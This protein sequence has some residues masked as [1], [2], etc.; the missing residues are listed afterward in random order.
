MYSWCAYMCDEI[1]HSASVTFLENLLTFILN[2]QTVYKTRN[3]LVTL[4]HLK[5]WTDV[6]FC[7]CV[8]FFSDISRSLSPWSFISI[9]Y[10][11]PV[12]RMITLPAPTPKW[13]SNLT[14]SNLLFLFQIPVLVT[15]IS[16]TNHP[17]K[18]GLS[19][20]FVVVHRIQQIPSM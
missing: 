16:S 3:S 11:Y 9:T 10:F 8:P 1:W 18:V 15:Q 13:N 2:Q 4:A 14:H 20:A 12:N 17:V 5:H 19:D 7:Y 6:M